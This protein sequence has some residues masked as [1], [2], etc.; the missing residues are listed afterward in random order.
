M[1]DRFYSLFNFRVLIAFI[2]IVLGIL[3]RTVWKVGDNF[4]FV[5]SAALLSGSYLGIGWAIAVPIT[6]MMITDLMFG[7]T[8][9]FIFTW[10]AY[11]LIGVLG[12]FVLRM[13]KSKIKNQ[14]ENVK[15]KINYLLKA[16]GLG[17]I[18]SIVFFIWTNFGVWLLDSWSMYPKTITGL[19]DAYIMGLP[20]L[21]SN[22]LGNL[23]FVPLSFSFFELVKSFK[24]NNM[25]IFQKFNID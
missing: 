16:T 15:I 8:N 10:S 18:S 17:V 3:F 7:N 25:F 4:E 12:W 2:L 21:K 11:A 1:S 13:Q 19:F 22:L 20:F 24:L 23:F 9:I 5:T 6:I 14:N